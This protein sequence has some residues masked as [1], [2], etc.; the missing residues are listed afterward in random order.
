MSADLG[1]AQEWHRSLSVCLSAVASAPGGLHEAGD[2]CAL[3][4]V[5]V[6]W[7]PQLP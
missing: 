3:W 2:K 6:Q 5:P 7:I 1:G 4:S